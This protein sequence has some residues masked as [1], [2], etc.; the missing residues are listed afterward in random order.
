MIILPD[1]EKQISHIKKRHTGKIFTVPRKLY[2][3][4][5]DSNIIPIQQ[6]RCVTFL[7]I[8]VNHNDIHTLFAQAKFLHEGG[9]VRTVFAL[10]DFEDHFLEI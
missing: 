2:A 3:V 7:D 8:E 10:S 4:D 9:I 1:L 5:G 6:D